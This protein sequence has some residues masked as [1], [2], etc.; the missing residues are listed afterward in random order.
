MV[1]TKERGE[2][3]NESK[4]YRTDDADDDDLID[5][6]N[7]KER[8]ERRERWYVCVSELGEVSHRWI[9]D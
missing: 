3:E 8:K 6:F 7:T 5:R 1:E 9:W 2:N 4:V